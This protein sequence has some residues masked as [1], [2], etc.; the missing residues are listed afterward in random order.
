M[1]DSAP[2]VFVCVCT[3]F[4]CID[5]YSDVPSQLP[6]TPTTEVEQTCGEIDETCNLSAES[7]SED[8]SGIVKWYITQ[9]SFHVQLFDLINRG[10][11]WRRSVGRL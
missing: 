1:Y 7:D 8:E 9:E 3:S 6:T 10:V 2:R 5:G 4:L 11:G